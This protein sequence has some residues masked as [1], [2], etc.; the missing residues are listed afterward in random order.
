[1]DN[2][3]EGQSKYGRIYKVA[4]PRKYLFLFLSLNSGGRRKH[5]R[6]QDVRARQDRL[7]QAGGRD[8]QA[9]GRHCFYPVL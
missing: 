7:G 5:V 8:H 2:F 4:G 1:M 3:E 9:R 6:F